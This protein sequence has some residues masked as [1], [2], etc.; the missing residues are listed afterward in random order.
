[1]VATPLV[2]VIVPTH[3]RPDMLAEALASV[4]AQTFDDYEI[5][6]VSNGETPENRARSRAAAAA[7]DC[8][9]SALDAGSVSAARNLGI[10]R[11]R[12]EWIAFLDDDDLWRP[13][14]LERQL[15]DA[16][17]TGAD[18]LL[19]G[20]SFFC[21]DGSV[22]ACDPHLPAGWGYTRAFG[23]IWWTPPS[24][25]MV[26]RAV[27]D[28]TG[29]FD[30][31]LRLGE[32]ID[33]WRRISWRHA[34]YLSDD[35]LVSIRRGRGHQSLTQDRKACCWYDLLHW[36]KMI[37]DTPRDLRSELPAT[38]HFI[39]PRLAIL[40]LPKWLR[41]PFHPERLRRRWKALASWKS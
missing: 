2:S 8:R 27:F 13:A 38:L 18:M 28:R 16:G 10:S 22:L 34:I 32:D 5:I 4:R 17:R 33:M 30:V 25:V 7:H 6:V 36:R 19:S 20:Y 35:V 14:K 11:A 21:P 40:T 31:D 37:Q 24:G 3:N 29:M 39:L 1:M 26:R 12:G 9:W 15:A 23:S 41:Q